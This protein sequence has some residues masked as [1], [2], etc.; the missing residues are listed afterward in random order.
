MDEALRKAIGRLKQR[1]GFSARRKR[2]MIQKSPRFC[3]GSLLLVFLCLPLVLRAQLS[4]EDKEKAQQ[5]VSGTLYS[6]IDYPCRYVTRFGTG[7]S[8]LLE[9]SPNGHD[10]QRQLNDLKQKH[11][12]TSTISTSIYWAEFPNRGLNHGE[13][14]FNGDT[15]TYD[16]EDIDS[17]LE[18]GFDFIQIHNIDDFTK[19]FNLVFSKVPL[20]EEHPEWPDAVKQ[21]ISAHTLIVGMTKE[22]VIDVIGEPVEVEKG[23]ENGVKIEIW[24]S[25]QDRGAPGGKQDIFNGAGEAADRSSASTGFPLLLRFQDEILAVY[26]SGGRKFF[27][28][29]RQEA[30]Q[31]HQDIGIAWIDSQNSRALVN[32]SG[33]WDSEFGKLH[34]IQ[35]ENSR[36]VLGNG[37]GYQ[38]KGVVSG[39]GFYFAFETRGRVTYCAEVE[40]V[41][42]TSFTGVYHNRVGIVA[43]GMCT[44]K[45]RTL[46]LRKK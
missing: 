7:P 17:G 45:A 36:D 37:G 44:S 39:K 21:A 30:A 40:Q 46:T 31:D 20:Q 9:V 10:Y 26:G 33:D 18:V 25:R 32:V 27:I 34:L 2:N 15:I 16:G 4:N 24:T 35:A 43:P 38:I 11:G 13:L 22:Q 42:D 28:A 23:E 5:M 6:R 12:V 14:R 29:G 8:S 1:D 19:A 3:M 41:N